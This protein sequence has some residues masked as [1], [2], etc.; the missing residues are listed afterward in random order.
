MGRL[1]NAR[2]ITRRGNQEWVTVQL[3]I[4]VDRI[5]IKESSHLVNTRV[6]AVIFRVVVQINDPKLIVD[7]H[8]HP[9]PTIFFLLLLRTMI[10]S[11]N[12]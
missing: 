1:K 3:L 12:R 10:H 5:S 9:K 11:T 2:C 4:H 6:L 7:V 8:T